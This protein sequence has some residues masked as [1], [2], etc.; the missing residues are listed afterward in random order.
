MSAQNLSRH[1]IGAS[2]ISAIA[3]LNPYASPW[4]VWQSQLGISP[5]IAEDDSE[6]IEWGHRNEPAIRKKYADATGTVL[7]VPPE[8]LFHPELAWARATPD[9]IAVRGAN[10]ERAAWSHLMQAKNV[11]YWPGRDWRGGPPAYVVLQEQWE[12]LVTDLTRADVAALIGGSEF[13][14]YTVHRDDRMI[15]DLITIGEEFWDRVKRKEQPPIDASD[16]CRKH[17]EAR[18]RADSAVELTAD[19]DLERAVSAWHDKHLAAKRLERE[20]DIIRNTVRKALA[21]ARASRL[22]TS[23]GVPALRASGGSPSTN[24][25]L[26][27]ELLGSTKCTPDEFAELVAANTETSAPTLALYPP[28][29][30]SKER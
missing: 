9:A 17:F 5:P 19:A 3:G 12:M 7:Y 22:V 4:D 21:D 15:S 11:G 2:E 13:R 6:A 26:I 1:G 28:T 23:T 8:S 27:A 10:S 30:W 24:W 16:A 20:M 18:L 25:R 29:Q 14:V